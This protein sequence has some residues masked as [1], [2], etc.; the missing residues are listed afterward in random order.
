MPS[1][2]KWWK[3]LEN[4]IGCENCSEYMFMTT[5]GDGLKIHCYKHKLTRR[6]LN[7]DSEGIF[8]RYENEGYK[9]LSKENALKWANG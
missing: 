1:L 5:S 4:A 2:L 8:Y 6:Y 3:P 7:V 9:I